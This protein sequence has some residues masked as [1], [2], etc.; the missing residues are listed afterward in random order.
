MP[1]PAPYDVE[2][3]PSVHRERAEAIAKKQ[4]ARFS[5]AMRTDP[6]STIAYVNAIVSRMTAR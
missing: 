1:K 3:A 2:L 4:R 5:F 6:R